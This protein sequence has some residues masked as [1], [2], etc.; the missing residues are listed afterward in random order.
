[1]A[2]VYTVGACVV[3][4]QEQTQQP[5]AKRIGMREFRADFSDFMRQVRDG[6]SFIVTC[7]GEAVA[8]IQPPQ[9]PVRTRTRRR[10]GGLRGKI[11]ISADFDTL[12]AQTL[13]AMEGNED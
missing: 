12:P 1:M 5:L 10:P 8:I 13:A 11:R 9:P 3:A 4:K 6:A 7:R 2:G